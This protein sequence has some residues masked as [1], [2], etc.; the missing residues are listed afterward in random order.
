MVEHVD[1][2]DSHET[3]GSRQPRDPFPDDVALIP[4]GRP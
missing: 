2:G 4:L 3:F 1:A